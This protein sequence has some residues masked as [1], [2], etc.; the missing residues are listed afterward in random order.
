MLLKKC[1]LKIL[2]FYIA[3]AKASMAG[4]KTEIIVQVRTVKIVEQFYNV[5]RR[6]KKTTKVAWIYFGW[7][8]KKI[9]IM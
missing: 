6:R 3:Q 1:T 8:N 5:S 2:I 4:L 9:F 7:C